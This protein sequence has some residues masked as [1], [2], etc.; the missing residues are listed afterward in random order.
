MTLL[1]TEN[2]FLVSCKVHNLQNSSLIL[3]NDSKIKPA[4]LR[5]GEKQSKHKEVS[6][7][8]LFQKNCKTK[9]RKNPH[10]P[11]ALRTEELSG[12]NVHVH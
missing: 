10:K 3:K 12:Y 11:Q 1:A 5:N 7:T 8:L 2:D 9:E 6:F 4:D